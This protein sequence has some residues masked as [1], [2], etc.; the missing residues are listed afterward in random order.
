MVSP[1]SAVPLP[2]DLG[3]KMQLVNTCSRQNV[4]SWLF[5]SEIPQCTKN[6]SLTTDAEFESERYDKFN[7]I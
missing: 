5:A 1:T 7:S 6:L 3:Q 4:V 2:G